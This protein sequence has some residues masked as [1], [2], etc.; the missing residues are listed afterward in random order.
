[1][2]LCLNSIG[3]CD[4]NTPYTLSPTFFSL[5]HFN[6]F[7]SSSI[8]P[9]FLAHLNLASKGPLLQELETNS[10]KDI[11]VAGKV[12]DVVVANRVGDVV[13][14]N[15]LKDI[16]ACSITI[17]VEDVVVANSVKDVVLF[18]RMS[19]EPLLLELVSNV[20]ELVALFKSTLLMS[21]NLSCITCS[22]LSTRASNL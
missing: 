8:P 9:V 22:L 14:A 19:K 20:K 6:R 16:I 4:R 5:L 18:K 7:I 11:T 3:F 21:F 1:M 10:G 13:V 17:N 15:T 12:E 2:R